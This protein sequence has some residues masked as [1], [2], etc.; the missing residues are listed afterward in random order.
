MQFGLSES[1]QILKDTARKF[2]SGECP[3]AEVRRL[4]ETATAYEPSLWLNM[5][6]PGFSGNICPE[7]KGG[8]G[9][10]AGGTC[11]LSEKGG[12]AG[13]PPAAFSTRGRAA[14]GGGLP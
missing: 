4:M 8:G 2:F 13:S 14:R 12:Y 7:E 1:Q 9:A 5:I 6:A 3:V 11:M 10:C